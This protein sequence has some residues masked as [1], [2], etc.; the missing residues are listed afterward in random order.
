MKAVLYL[1]SS[2]DRSDVSIDAQRRALREL[3]E[4]RDILIVGEYADAVESGKDDDRP[5]FQS[6]LRD[7]RDSH[8]VWDTVLVLDTARIAR[9]RHLSLIFEEQECK[10]RGIRVIYNSVPDSDPIT[11]MLLKS[12]LQAMDEWHSLTSKAKGLAGMSENVR[13]GWRA[14]GRPPKGYQLENVP[15]GAIRDGMPVTKSRLVVSDEALL[16]RAYLQKRANGISRADSMKGI[17]ASWPTT[18]LLSMENNALVYAGHTVW[19]RRTE[20]GVGT[21]KYRP[22]E[23]WVIQ[24]NTHEPL[25]S[26]AEADK[27]LAQLEVSSKTKA[28]AAKHSYL[29]A[30]LLYSPEGERWHGDGAGNYR[31][32]KGRRILAENVD[33]VIFNQVIADLESDAM[34]EALLQHYKKLSNKS[35]DNSQEQGIKQTIADIDKQIDTLANLTTQTSAPAALLRKIEDL[36]QRREV[37]VK[38]LIGL[39]DEAKIHQAIKNLKPADVRGMI[40]KLRADLEQG[41]PQ[42]MRLAMA[43]MIEKIVLD[44]KTFRASLTYRLGYVSGDKLASPRGVELIPAYY[45]NS[46]VQIPHRRRA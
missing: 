20:K 30:G 21:T 18:S 43:D 2:K 23:E 11:E 31:L 42:L 45:Y 22:R 28:K 15:T 38:A 12:I 33:K 5:A 32:G 35:R 10:K 14:G 34:I 27:I 40:R 4:K 36:E 41:N 46:V 13:Q 44:D 3:A 8:R 17:D 24:Q 25:I 16:V 7:M 26:Q 29:L 9:R 37:S 1:R 19:N 6:M 39:Q